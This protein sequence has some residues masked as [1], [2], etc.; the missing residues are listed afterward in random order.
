MP[1]IGLTRCD[2]H[3]PPDNPSHYPTRT[4][5]QPA[6]VLDIPEREH[7]EE[8]PP[9]GSLESPAIPGDYP[10]PLQCPCLTFIAALV[11]ASKFSEDICRSNVSWAALSGIPLVEV[12]RC[13]RALGTALDW[14]LWVGKGFSPSPAQ[15]S[16]TDLPPNVS[17]LPSQGLVSSRPPPCPALFPGSDQSSEDSEHTSD[18]IDPHTQ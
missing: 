8:S 16:Q 9:Q 4:S 3:H 7:L 6:R 12:G 5:R 14:R 13:E 1:Q 11:L 10:S 2:D 17:L 15:I 18:S